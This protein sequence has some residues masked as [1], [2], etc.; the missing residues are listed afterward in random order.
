MPVVAARRMADSSNYFNG[1]VSGE[2]NER[3]KLER[4]CRYTYVGSYNSMIY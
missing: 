1:A 2:A 3:G 4:L